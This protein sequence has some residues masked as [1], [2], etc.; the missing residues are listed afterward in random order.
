MRYTAII[1]FLF[2]FLLLNAQDEK[3]EKLTIDG[4]IVTALITADG[5]TL[6]IA[7]LDE[8]SVS[9]IRSF[10]SKKDER[11]YWKYRRYAL[12]VYPFAL[13]SIKIF[14]EVEVATETMSKR[15]RKR[16]IRKL[17]KDLKKEFKDP[18]KKLTKT[19]GKI[20]MKMIEKELDTPMYTLLKGLKGSWSAGYWNTLGSLWGYKLKE[21]Y[22]KGDDPM[23][24]AVLH[25]FDV[26]YDIEDY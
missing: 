22:I 8:L 24:D 7:D 16:Y 5:D 11:L 18:L 21:G 25:D 2:S 17:N 6:L 1:L 3:R 13:K 20:L 26:S 10:K 15:K 14:K 9:S 19:Q 23:M 4:E 12:K